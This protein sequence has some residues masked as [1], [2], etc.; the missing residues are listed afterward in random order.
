MMA[1]ANVAGTTTV[2]VS[3][4]TKAML[5]QLS[6]GKSMDALLRELA[7]LRAGTPAAVGRPGTYEIEIGEDDLPASFVER[8]ERIE[9][10]LS[11]LEGSTVLPDPVTG[12]LFDIMR[13]PSDDD[14]RGKGGEFI[15]LPREGEEFAREGSVGAFG[16]APKVPG[17][18]VRTPSGMY[19]TDRDDTLSEE[20]VA[21]IRA[22]HKGARKGKDA[23]VP[24]GV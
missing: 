19:L 8:V 14:R 5:D 7:L 22:K 18:W 9:E 3:G 1:R 17:F 2:R 16:K 21:K 12:V 20:L 6:G 10:M 15:L 13:A 23:K 4:Q 24:E 11:G